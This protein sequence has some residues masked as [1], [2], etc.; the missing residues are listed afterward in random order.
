MPQAVG[1]SHLVIALNAFSGAIAYDRQRKIDYRLAVIL[2]GVA[3]PFVLLSTLLVMKLESPWFRV[4]FAVILGTMA[5]YVVKRQ[6]ILAAERGEPPPG[7]LRWAAAASIVA[8][9]VAS[10]LGIGGGAFHVPILCLILGVPI[11]RATATSQFILFLT[12]MAA[13]TSLMLQ[14]KCELACSKTPRQSLSDAGRLRADIM[15]TS[16]YGA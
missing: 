14:G 7:A 8:A 11:H 6:E 16:P 2:G 9:F 4:G 13:A 10:L 1:T 12:S 5:I 3:I 15:G